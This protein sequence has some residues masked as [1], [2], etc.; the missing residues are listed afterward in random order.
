MAPRLIESVILRGDKAPLFLCQ[1]PVSPAKSVTQFVS[2]SPVQ[3]LEA[4]TVPSETAVR[5]VEIPD[6]VYMSPATSNLP[7]G[8]V[9]PTPTLPAPSMVM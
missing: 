5:K 7:L 3:N 2:P 8:L 9:S 1:T 4:S 6:E